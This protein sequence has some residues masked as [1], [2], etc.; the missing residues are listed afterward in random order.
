MFNG[1][2]AIGMTSSIQKEWTFTKFT[3]KRMCSACQVPV[4]CGFEEAPVSFP[5]TI[6]PCGGHQRVKV[7][8]EIDVDSGN[9]KTVSVD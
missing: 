3:T 9:S 4:L 5:S 7:L 6:S 8:L 2:H 1:P